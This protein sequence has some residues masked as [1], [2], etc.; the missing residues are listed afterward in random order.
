MRSDDSDLWS[1]LPPPAGAPLGAAQE[2]PLTLVERWQR[3]QRYNRERIRLLRQRLPNS[4]RIVF[5]LL[6][7]LLHQAAA[8]AP[9]GSDPET[10]VQG[11]VNF[12]LRKEVLDA[13]AEHFP[14]VKWRQGA[15]M[16]KPM[17]LSLLAIGSMGTMAQT[18]QS[19]LDLWIIIKSGVFGTA[20]EEVLQQRLKEIEAW[21]H[22]QKL[23]VHFFP[24]TIEQ[25]Q[26]SDFG[27]LA[28]EGCGSALKATLKEEFYRTHLL[29]QGQTPLWWVVDPG[30]DKLT[31]LLT[32][33][34]VAEDPA[35]PS[36][37]F[38][39][40]G[41]VGPIAT[42]E[43]LGAWLWQMVKARRHPFKSLLKSTLL[44]RHLQRENPPPLCEVLKTRILHAHTLDPLD[45]DPYLILVDTL[46]EE[47]E[48]VNDA[49]TARLLKQCFLLQV[50]S[51]RRSEPPDDDDQ[52]RLSKLIARWG[53]SASDLSHLADVDSWN[54][55]DLDRLGREI[56]KYLFGIFAKVHSWLRSPNPNTIRELGMLECKLSC[57][58]AESPH[59]VGLLSTGFFSGNLNQSQLLLVEEANGW[60]IRTSPQSRPLLEHAI[61]LEEL[62]AFIA[63]NGLFGKNTI[64]SFESTSQ[65]NP[66]SLRIRL[67]RM[68]RIFG[69]VRPDQ[70]PVEEFGRP[71]EPLRSLVEVA[72]RSRPAATK[73]G[74]QR[75]TEQWDLLEYGQEGQCLVETLLSWT[76]TSWGTLVNQNYEGVAGLVDFLTTALSQ[77]IAYPIYTMRMVSADGS[78]EGQGGA[79]R[80]E[81]L[82]GAARQLLGTCNLSTDALFVFHP[83][84]VAYVLLRQGTELTSIGPLTDDELQQVL[85]QPGPPDKRIAID[86]GCQ[87]LGHLREALS[88]A[89]A[90]QASV[91]RFPE[92]SGARV[93]VVDPSGALFWGGQDSN[94]AAGLLQECARALPGWEP[95][96]APALRLSADQRFES[97]A[98]SGIGQFEPD[99]VVSGEVA[100]EGHLEYC[101]YGKQPKTRSLEEAATWVLS[102]SAMGTE[103]PPSLALLEVTHNGQ[104]LSLMARLRLHHALTRALREACTTLLTRLKN[105]SSNVKLP[106]H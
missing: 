38:V 89:V 79:R 24:L 60:N 85:S 88:L 25:V 92:V 22:R 10:P 68:A 36:G 49:T 35:L 69:G 54:I 26:N 98:V 21:C 37:E 70:V 8:G 45:L 29:L 23:E 34:R 42:E 103:R 78:G 57:A 32:V 17:F 104:T 41:P 90:G 2:A 28:G 4:Q 61:S 59:Q 80:M 81:M 47:C 100:E 96:K 87:R 74:H 67:E 75:L 86:P 16:K 65:P 27:R 5:D 72:T 82:Y 43:F 52:A 46:V 39:D 83:G 97:A 12:N 33:Q 11:I 91:F 77:Q 50:L 95:S 9:G 71:V 76:V 63:L 19:D 84:G 64:L 7:W 40:L 93:V 55:G 31:Y 20:L 106:A 48:Q 99:V 30:A 6:P 102:R 53:W 3:F 1:G 44:T 51:S 18:S 105:S 58:R 101:L 73:N 66:V 62:L 15:S 13:A 94:E 14:K 56:D